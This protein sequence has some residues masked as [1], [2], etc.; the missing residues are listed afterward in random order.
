MGG[1][2]E[3]AYQDG[4]LRLTAK[5]TELSSGALEICSKILRIKLRLNKKL[6]T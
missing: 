6:N 1:E 2:L 4:K 3:V 5:V